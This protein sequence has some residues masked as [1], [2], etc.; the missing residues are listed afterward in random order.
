MLRDADRKILAR[1]VECGVKTLGYMAQCRADEGHLVV[2]DRRSQ[3]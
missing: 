1:T 3:K 2:M